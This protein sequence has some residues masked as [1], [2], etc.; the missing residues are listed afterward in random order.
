MRKIGFSL[1]ILAA[2]LSF[3]PGTIRADPGAPTPAPPPPPWGTWGKA[4]PPPPASTPIP[5]GSSAPGSA[6]DRVPA[7]AI[8]TPSGN[9]SGGQSSPNPVQQVVQQITQVIVP[10][11]AFVDV[12][13]LVLDLALR[14]LFGNVPV[15]VQELVSFLNSVSW[16][17]V[18]PVGHW[19]QQFER[20]HRTTLP[21]AAVMAALLAAMT[22]ALYFLGRSVGVPQ[23][24]R[25]V[26]AEIAAGVLLAYLT[27]DIVR[28]S[29]LLT[30]QVLKAVAPQ[31]PLAPLKAML[32]QVG[33]QIGAS[34]WEA[35]RGLGLT[36]LGLLILIPMFAVSFF[37]EMFAVV[38]YATLLT[39]WPILLYAAAGVG[40]LVAAVWMARPTRFA[41]WLWLKLL[42]VV[43]LA[44]I[45]V[46]ILMS[47]MSGMFSA[48]S[49]LAGL[50][51]L[52][53]MLIMISIAL[54]V[55]GMLTR[56]VTTAAQAGAGMAAGAFKGLVGLASLA[57]LPAA[58]ALAG[59]AGVAGAAKAAGAAGA[60][61]AGGTAGWLATAATGLR[62]GLFLE[63]LGHV[64]GSPT[65][66]ALGRGVSR[67]AQLQA[68][69]EQE[70]AGI[71]QAEAHNRA[72]RWS[73]E[74]R[75]VLLDRE[76]AHAQAIFQETRAHLDRIGR[77]HPDLER[78][79]KQI[80]EGFVRELELRIPQ[81]PAP[82]EI[83]YAVLKAYGA[84]VAHY[85]ADTSPTSPQIAISPEQLDRDRAFGRDLAR[86]FLGEGGNA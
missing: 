5:A 53:Q 82:R 1:L 46:T 38:A 55:A 23:D 69:A 57:L 41:W 15:M 62:R 64:L 77:S 2:L 37:A 43:N 16:D 52:F 17:V 50:F 71:L 47:A 78:R 56:T 20:I 61:G 39:A 32:D 25:L 58:P 30:L 67:W 72:M 14:L 85:I 24:P 59:A 18:Y 11:G 81:W 13:N 79:L 75:P 8:P 33:A 68:A 83:S 40:P 34:S 6:G 27:L 28:L 35:I 3:F 10:V 12:L 9:S 22:V 70:K 19:D 48:R 80:E 51:Q 60:A 76:R 7:A 63:T 73:L 21:A 44:V 49:G 54:S 65:L 84:Q 86:R 31:G 74:V 42:L 26:L 45:V 29:G 4:T 36:G 66:A